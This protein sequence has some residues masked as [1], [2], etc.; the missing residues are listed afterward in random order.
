MKKLK[1][2]LGGV[3]ALAL[4]IS[5]VAGACAPAAP[6]E[7]AEEIAELEAEI[8]DLED[9]V[10]AEKAKTAAEKAEVSDLEKEI[11][12]LKKPAEVFEWRIQTY[13]PTASLVYELNEE[14]CDTV[15]EA[16]G[17]RVELTLYPGGSLTPL[18]ET[19][20]AIG[21]GALE[22]SVAYGTA[23]TGSIPEAGMFKEQP[24][25][26]LRA[27]FYWRLFYTQGW[28]EIFE[29]LLA[30]HNAQ[31]VALNVF[32]GYEPVR[33][34]VPIRSYADYEGKKIRMGSGVGPFYEEYFGVSVVTMAG[35]ELYTACQ[36]G[37]IDGFEYSSGVAD[38]Q[39]GFHEVAPYIIMPAW[40]GPCEEDIIANM[41]AWNSLP[42]DIQGILTRVCT[43]YGFWM[44][45]K[46]FEADREAHKK[47][48]DYGCEF[49]WLP[50]DEVAQTRAWAS[51]WRVKAAAEISP[52]AVKMFEI[53]ERLV[54]EEEATKGP[55][56]LEF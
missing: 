49:I 56:P 46:T 5:L 4:A 10:A 1:S 12:A 34:S 3:L 29:D 35:G 11:A 30:P 28:F 17:G 37:T 44:W 52:T 23:Y 20:E 50:E 14:L 19:L 51:E 2:L 22:M 18:Y 13:M 8:A 9:D 38:W 53:Y 55:L 36:L 26:L 43:E 40:D 6:E 45:A 33:M 32:P 39:Q 15:L 54:A 24:H 41:D 31:L 25:G 42:G 7:V 47:M 27:D 16:T 21:T 48:L